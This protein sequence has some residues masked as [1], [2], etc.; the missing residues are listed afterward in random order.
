MAKEKTIIK[1]LRNNKKVGESAYTNY[2]I[3][4]KYAKK[5]SEEGFTCLILRLVDEKEWVKF[6][7]YPPETI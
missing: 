7:M 6:M 3:A 5:K 1:L 4:M 2:D